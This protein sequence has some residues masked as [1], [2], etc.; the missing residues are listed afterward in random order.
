MTSQTCRGDRMDAV[1]AAGARWKF[2]PATHFLF[3]ILRS[4]VEAA[5]AAGVFPEC[6]LDRKRDGGMC[7]HCGVDTIR[8]HGKLKRSRGSAREA[9]MRRWGLKTRIRKSLWDADHILPVTKS[10]AAIGLSIRIFE[11]SVFVAIARSLR[12]SASEFAASR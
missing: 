7:A 5:L 11:R 6:I 2:R 12:N 8:E 3:G 10:A 4:R 1:C 9:L